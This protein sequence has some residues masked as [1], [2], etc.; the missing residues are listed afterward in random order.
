MNEVLLRLHIDTGCGTN[1]RWAKG[2][3]GGG[4]VL[5]EG[6]G[7]MQGS[8]Q[9]P[10]LCDDSPLRKT[11]IRNIVFRDDERLGV[12]VMKPLLLMSSGSVAPPSKHQELTENQIT[13]LRP[14]SIERF[15]ER[16]FQ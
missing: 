9:A 12:T 2:G 3:G 14:D 5:Y 13:P 16:V 15:P 10:V 1:H 11:G 6:A 4:C 8:D 7:E